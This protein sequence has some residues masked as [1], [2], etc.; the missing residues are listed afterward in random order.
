MSILYIYQFIDII[1]FNYY[2]LPMT[3]EFEFFMIFASVIFSI[4]GIFSCI[5][6]YRDKLLCFSHNRQDQI[7]D[8]FD[9][10]FVDTDTERYIGG[11]IDKYT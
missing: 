7:H 3:T 4:F 9:P 11:Y 2:I 10:A 1:T 6:C 5:L 8:Q